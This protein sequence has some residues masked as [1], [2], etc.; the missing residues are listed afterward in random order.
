MVACGFSTLAPALIFSLQ[1]WQRHTI[2][3]TDIGYTLYNGQGQGTL[4][5]IEGFKTPVNA[6]VVHMD[7]FF[8]LYN[9]RSHYAIE[10]R[11]L[12][13]TDDG[14]AIGV[15]ATGLFTNTPSISSLLA[16]DPGVRAQD[17]GQ[18]YSAS[19]WTFD[20]S[21]D[22]TKYRNLAD[23]MFV[24]NFRLMPGNS[25]KSS[26]FNVEFRLS[27]VTPGPRIRGNCPGSE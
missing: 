14:V 19:V 23:S 27:K 24:G 17:W 18:S 6:T 15:H 8:N 9:D 5:S 12:V 21:K 10:P 11:G 7:D 20:V 1:I 4:K 13:V 3:P 25:D 26:Y 16:G 22:S 2:G